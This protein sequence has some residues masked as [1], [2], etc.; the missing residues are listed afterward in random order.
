MK[1]EDIT[2]TVSSV[3]AVT[4]MI[5]SVVYFQRVFYD[6]D[7]ILIEDFIINNI[8]KI[9]FFSKIYLEIQQ[10]GTSAIP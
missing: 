4:L 8:K 10:I 3:I 6:I 2:A 1:S 7:S 9:R 5:G